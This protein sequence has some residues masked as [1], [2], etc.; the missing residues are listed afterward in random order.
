MGA[1]VIKGER[2]DVRFAKAR[3]R[4]AVSFAVGV[5]AFALAMALTAWQMAVLIGWSTT[6]G[7]T[8]CWTVSAVL[9]RDAAATKALAT[10][11]DASPG[12]ADLLLTAA[13]S[14]S[15]LAIGL[16]LVKAAHDKG[17]AKAVLTAMA[18][19]AVVLSWGV[20][21]SV[22]TLRYAH[23]YYRGG[24]GIDF[25]EDADPDYRDFAYL[26]LTVGM[27]FQVSDTDLKTKEI[28][29]TATRHA[30]LSYLFGAVI[31]AMAINVVASLLSK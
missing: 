9:H 6:A 3:T 29:R 7:V 19:F 12:V 17:S 4:A 30:L 21:H 25:N 14:G 31:I 16:A 13:A 2:S 27:T 22:F 18:V 28:R 10:R 1:A 20:V 24:G 8:V 23:L 26:A 15:L 11:E 5:A